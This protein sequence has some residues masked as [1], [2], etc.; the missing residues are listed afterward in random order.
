[1]TDA[2]ARPDIGALQ[3]K[4]RL[5]RKEIIEMTTKAGS[6]HPSSSMSA[7]EVIVSLYFGGV[8]RQKPS[9][10]QWP[11]RDRFV[12]SK[13]HGVPAQYA[14]LAEAGYFPKEWL[15]DLRQIGA[16]L[17]G[18]PNVHSTPGIEACTGS[19]GQG[20]SIG[21]GM[22]LAGWL[23]KKDFNV[24]VMTGDGEIDEGQIWEAA[25]SASKYKLPNLV[26]IIDQ[27]GFQQ[28]GATGDILPME[29][30]AAKAE[31]FG[32]HARVINGNDMA[33]AL[34]ALQEARAW[35]DGPYCLIS[36][37]KK[38]AGVSFVEGDFSYHGKPLTQEETE[39]ALE[40][41]GWR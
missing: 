2:T 24:F 29:P 21:V 11:D 10:P 22:A 18:H 4:A 32:W 6:G 9:E 37:T 40:E 41:L 20:L 35:K 13:G 14:A 36:K 3:E 1:M 23:D 12:L 28:T 7:V 27:N 5:L 19:L 38:G 15:N 34:N 17:E 26:W 16:P 8:L 31:A 39:R 30:L 25:A 33:E